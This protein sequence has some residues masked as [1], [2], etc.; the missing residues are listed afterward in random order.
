[1]TIKKELHVPCIRYA[2]R[3]ILPG[4]FLVVLGLAYLL[5]SLPTNSKLV[6]RFKRSWTPFLTLE[7]A[8][9]LLATPA[10]PQQENN[11][12][13]Q[14]SLLRIREREA[15]L[16]RRMAMRLTVPIAVLSL[17]EVIYWMGVFAYELLLG[18]LLFV[19][20]AGCQLAAWGYAFVRPLLH[21]TATPPYNIFILL[22]IQLGTASLGLFG[23]VYDWYAEG[24][25]WPGVG[26]IL[27]ELADLTVIL[28]LLLV[29]LNT[30]VEPID[31][32][33]SVGINNLA[34]P[35]DYTTIWG[36]M[37]FGF[38]DPV[39]E[40]GSKATLDESDVFELSPHHR[41]DPLLRR[42]AGVKGKTLLRRIWTANALDLL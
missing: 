29:I 4:S 21:P 11:T 19:L 7:D 2:W 25:S 33:D 6:R 15:L 14:P 3:G 17:L 27:G 40:K 28:G 26:T 10:A 30:P 22:L 1:M 23:N 8:R 16:R 39:I 31:P 20:I 38:V 13:G 5:P 42:F 18:D 32:K 35:E 37:T 34:S 24:I 9:Q 41:A 12:D 36:W